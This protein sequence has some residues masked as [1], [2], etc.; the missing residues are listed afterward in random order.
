MMAVQCLQNFPGF[1]RGL[2][3]FLGVS[4]PAA[5]VNSGLR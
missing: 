4:V 1:I 3:A 5:G 2:V